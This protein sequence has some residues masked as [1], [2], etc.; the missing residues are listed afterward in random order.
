MRRSSTFLAVCAVAATVSAALAV[1]PPAKAGA[2]ESL[3]ANGS[4]VA[5]PRF[6]G[7]ALHQ[8]PGSPRV[9]A[10]VGQRTLF[11]SPTRLAV[12]GASGDWLA[13]I[14]AALGNRVRGY[15]H[16]SKVHVVRNPYTLEVDRS[17]RRL[18]VW[19]LGV[20]LREVALAIGAPA[21]PTPLGRFS[22]TDKLS[23]F[24]SSVYGCCVLALSGRQ[25]R[26]AAGWS[27]GD[28]LAIHAGSGMGGA[29]SNGCLRA[30]SGDMRYLLATL[31]LGTQVV[32][33]G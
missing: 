8:H 31:P 26:L 18:T 6:G 25:T 15:V 21:T 11:G 23:N 22:V 4:D 16:R 32:I 19:R 33:H 10:H 3:Y 13:V 2:F 28:R 1:S 20:R 12:V 30:H 7:V 24:W 9:L 14:S 27:G 5:S 29:V 17:G